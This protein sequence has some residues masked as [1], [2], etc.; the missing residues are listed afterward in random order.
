MFFELSSLPTS[1]RNEEQC[2]DHKLGS[3]GRLSQYQERRFPPGDESG[4]PVP[5]FGR[6][7][8]EAALVDDLDVGLLKMLL[9]PIG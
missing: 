9:Y 6:A 4:R 2:R 7:V 1:Q 8:G 5:K 3:G